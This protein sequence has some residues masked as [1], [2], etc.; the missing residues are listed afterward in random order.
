MSNELTLTGKKTTEISS[1]LAKYKDSIIEVL[2][3]HVTPERMIQMM[4]YTIAK[5]PD[6]ANCTIESIIGAFV[7]TSILKFV[8]VDALGLCYYAPYNTKQKDGSYKKVLSFGIMYKGYINLARR[9]N[10]IKNIYAE[11]VYKDDVFEYELGLNPKIYHKPNMESLQLDKDITHAYAV[12]EYLNGGR[13]FIVLPRR[14]IEILRMM[15]PNQK[16]NNEPTGYWKIGYPEMAKA[17]VI[18][19]LKPYLPLSLDIMAAMST[20]GKVLTLDNFNKDGLK[21][22][23]LEY[24]D[25][26]VLVEYTQK[27]IIKKLKAEQTKYNFSDMKMTEILSRY[28]L[29]TINDVTNENIESVLDEMNKEFEYVRVLQS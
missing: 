29:N 24:D 9:S 23:T 13:N 5:N 11:C 20:D 25:D 4:T 27:E 7:Q 16:D 17:K 8:P 28:E 21:P 6:I 19:K 14:R 22:E 12:A 3:Q 2:P 10:E 18:N 15:N 26:D 1:L